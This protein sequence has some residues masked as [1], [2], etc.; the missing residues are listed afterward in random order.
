MVKSQLWWLLLG[1]CSFKFKRPNFHDLP[2]LTTTLLHD[3]PLPTR[4]HF[5]LGKLSPNSLLSAV[6]PF[7]QT[8]AAPPQL[9]PSLRREILAFLLLLSP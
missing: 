9:I 5:F 3:R 6:F 2:V 4:W 8:L 1:L 7:P